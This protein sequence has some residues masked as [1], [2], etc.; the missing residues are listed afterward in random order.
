MAMRER[1]RLNAT[2][3]AQHQK[4]EFDEEYIKHWIVNGHTRTINRTID[5]MLLYI[6]LGVQQAGAVVRVVHT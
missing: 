2:A 3:S 4:A 6:K 5:R 1:T